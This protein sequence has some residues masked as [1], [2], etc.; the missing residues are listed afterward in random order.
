[1]LRILLHIFLP[2]VMRLIAASAKNIEN[3]KFIQR[4]IWKEVEITKTKFDDLC[5]FINFK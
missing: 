5:L 2:G 3:L 1:M 4:W